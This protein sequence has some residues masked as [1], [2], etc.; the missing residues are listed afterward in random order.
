MRDHKF[1]FFEETKMEYINKS[2]E[3]QAVSLAQG[4]PRSNTEVYISV[5]TGK[6]KYKTTSRS[7]NKLMGPTTNNGN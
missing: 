1:F 5:Q 6:I 2:D 3:K 7:P 4:V